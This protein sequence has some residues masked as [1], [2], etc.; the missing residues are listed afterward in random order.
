VR[1][2]RQ[3]MYLTLLRDLKATSCSPQ[4]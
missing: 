1:T 2:R 4:E 3:Q